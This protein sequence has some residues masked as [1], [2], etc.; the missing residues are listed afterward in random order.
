MS[1]TDIKLIY[2]RL[3]KL[4]SAEADREIGGIQRPVDKGEEEFAEEMRVLRARAFRI[5]VTINGRGGE[6]LYGDEV[7]VFD[8][9]NRPHYVNAVYMTNVT[10]YQG[11]AGHR[12]DN[13]FE[14]F[15]D[16]SKPPLLDANTF[17]SSPTP[18]N[19]NFS[20]EASSD[21]WVAAASEAIDGVMRNKKIQRALI[22]RAFSYDFGLFFLAIPGTIYVSSRVAPAIEQV[23]H[24]QIFLSA[25]IYIYLFFFMLYLF[26]VLFGY[27]KWAFP[28]VELVENPDHALRH[29]V[30]WSAIVLGLIINFAYDLLT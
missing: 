3:T 30:F 14:L 27:T 6:T 26:R 15:L 25:G 16:F 22:H 9:P 5:T 19:S 10:A 17:V 18:N 13:A 24:G 29:R 8:S 11:V 2:E 12:P 7:S 4:V 20:I 1:W 21:A 23:S 28:T